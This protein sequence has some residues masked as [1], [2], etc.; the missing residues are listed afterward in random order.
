MIQILEE[1]KIIFVRGV[2][3]MRAIE[4]AVLETTGKK[5]WMNRNDWTIVGLASE[6]SHGLAT[7]M[8]YSP[9]DDGRPAVGFK[10]K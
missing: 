7:G 8:P 6:E 3:S 9:V 5:R 4:Q 2:R 10:I 1:S